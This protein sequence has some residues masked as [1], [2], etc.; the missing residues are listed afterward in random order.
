[1]A[2][3]AKATS[4]PD[5]PTLKESLTG[6]YSEE[7]WAA[8]DSE[9]NS[10]ENKGTWEVVLRSSIPL[11]TKVIPGTSVQRIKHLASGELS[12]FK[13]RWCCRR[14]LQA[15]EGVPY[16]P[17]V[18]WPTVRTGLLMAATHGWKS[19][20]VDFI[21]AFCQSPQP[22]DNPLYMELPQYYRPAGHEGKDVVLRKAST[23]KWTLQSY[24][25]S[26]SLAV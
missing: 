22:A 12:K 19:R 3:K 11:G 8:M 15:C 9:I 23:G 21:L 14:D 7:L 5:L 24:S 10:L 13:S 26:I 25:T 2:L 20:Q 16:S 4:D 18:G 17:L 1:M 6:P